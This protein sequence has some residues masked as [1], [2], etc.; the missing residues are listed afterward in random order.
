MKARRIAANSALA[1]AGDLASKIGAL[2]VVVLAARLLAVRDFAIVATALASASLL[3]TA[4]DFG[5]GTLLTRDGARNAE[6]RGVLFRA[7]LEARIPMAAVVLTGAPL[8]GLW[9]AGPLTALAVAA[10]AV[11]GALTASVLGLYR[12]CQD[13]RPE[14]VQR[15]TASALSVAAVILCGSF[16]PRANVLLAALAASS[17]AALLPLILRSPSI[18]G[19]ERAVSPQAALRRMAPIGLLA[20]ATVAYYRSGTLALAAL[21][22]PRETA[23]FSI[24]A[25]V[26]FGLL[27]LP[28]A[29]TTALLPRLAAEADFRRFVGCARQTLAWTLAI[30]MPVSG[31][32]AVAGP[33]ALRLVLGRDYA[34]AG[35]PFE[36]LCLGIPAIATSG[37]IGT[38][39]LALGHVRELAVQVGCSLVVNLTA[40]ALLVPALGAA[41]AS[42]A[43]LACEATGLI[44]LMKTAR[45]TLPGLIAMR[46]FPLDEGLEI[47][48]AATARSQAIG[49]A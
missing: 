6:S 12:S 31:A 25:S 30:A 35:L 21:S 4:L 16:L 13:V 27:M 3:S 39:L 41:G 10:L 9:L 46:P 34:S 24:A 37:V 26:A 18:A 36:L 2:A 11:S 28:N 44:L 20:L 5:A 19:F 15:V 32:A 29:I 42:L 14:A 23:A 1:L 38:A 22:D 49:P 48:G 45:R 17:L 33:Y 47:H 40:L 8:V 43:T 7:L